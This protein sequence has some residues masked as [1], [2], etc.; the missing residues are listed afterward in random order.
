MAHDR[1]ESSVVVNIFFY[2][3]LFGPS[4]RDQN[5]SCF[6]RQ[7]D[8]SIDI[9]TMI[10]CCP[11]RIGLAIR[12]V[13]AVSWGPWLNANV[14]Y[15]IVEVKYHA[16]FG[17]RKKQIWSLFWSLLSARVRLRRVNN[18]RVERSR[19]DTS[20]L[21]S[22]TSIFLDGLYGLYGSLF[23]A[24]V[25]ISIDVILF[26]FVPPTPSFLVYRTDPQPSKTPGTTGLNSD[27]L[28]LRNSSWHLFSLAI[29]QSGGG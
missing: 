15:L 23:R 8:W 13:N 14:W 2:G 17:I 1:L 10:L 16:Q 26:A 24:S 4:S 27:Y 9:T 18:Q 21:N 19:K 25:I 12:A 7:Q 28:K 29:Y 20:R 3:K 6:S 5:I 11:Q 22:R